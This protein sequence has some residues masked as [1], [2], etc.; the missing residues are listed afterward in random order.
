MKRLFYN[1]NSTNDFHMCEPDNRQTVRWIE[2]KLDK[3]IGFGPV[4]IVL[5]GDPAPPKG[6]QPPIFGL[7]PSWPN[8]W[9][10]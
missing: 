7:R 3:E 5:G 6:T 9:M 1:W 4:R 10:D 2:M 8:D